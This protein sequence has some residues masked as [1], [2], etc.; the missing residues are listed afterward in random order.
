[1]L[2]N[3]EIL[4]VKL[5]VHFLSHIWVSRKTKHVNTIFLQ[6]H[7]HLD[8][9]KKH[10]LKRPVEVGQASQCLAVLSK[11]RVN[12][13]IWGRFAEKSPCGLYMLC[14]LFSHCTGISIYK[15]ASSNLE[16]KRCPW[17]L[18]YSAFKL[19]YW[20]W[21][22]T[23]PKIAFKL[24]SFR[25]SVDTY[26]W[27]IEVLKTCWEWALS[28]VGKEQKILEWGYCRPSYKLNDFFCSGKQMC[29]IYASNVQEV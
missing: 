6:K 11:V 10:M 27:S 4:E 5:H 24:L 26:C 16:T 23:E 7:L 29:G 9:E 12:S 3:W 17:T 8:V 19:C 20:F 13:I 18:L 2:S 14:C 1:M 28:P 15:T 22:F 25:W 21:Q